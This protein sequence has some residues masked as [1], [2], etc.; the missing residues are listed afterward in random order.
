MK[1]STHTEPKSRII[2]KAFG[3]EAIVVQ[4]MI[5]AVRQERAVIV[6]AL[7]FFSQPPILVAYLRQGKK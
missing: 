7:T 2:P 6:P 4:K 1:F 3:T 5:K